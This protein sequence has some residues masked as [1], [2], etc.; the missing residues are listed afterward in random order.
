MYKD[1][2]WHED[3]HDGFTIRQR[4]SRNP[5]EKDMPGRKAEYPATGVSMTATWRPHLNRHLASKVH[6]K[7]VAI[8]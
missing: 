6:C 4:N 2:Y 7:Q 5:Y 1:S 8:A 3:A